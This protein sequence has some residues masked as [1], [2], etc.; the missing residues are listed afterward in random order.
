MNSYLPNPSYFTTCKKCKCALK[1]DSYAI[2]TKSCENKHTFFF[3]CPECNGFTATA[4][5]NI[6]QEI[7]AEFVPKDELDDLIRKY[8][9]AN[10]KF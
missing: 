2:D 10:R 6:P 5:D 3:K 9:L 8:N 7:W 1:M 4:M